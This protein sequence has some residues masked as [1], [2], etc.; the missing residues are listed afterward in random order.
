MVIE[1][2]HS[3]YVYLDRTVFIEHKTSEHHF[4]RRLCLVVLTIAAL[5]LADQPAG[6][7]PDVSTMLKSSGAQRAFSVFEILAFRK[8]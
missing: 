3:L 1:I 4:H 6:L 2:L 5:I 7:R 8:Y